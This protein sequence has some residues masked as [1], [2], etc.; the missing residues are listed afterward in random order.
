ME[1]DWELIGLVAREETPYSVFAIFS[2]ID[3]NSGLLAFTASDNNE[4][5]GIFTDINDA[6]DLMYERLR[7]R[8]SACDSSHTFYD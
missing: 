1:H 2:I 5:I 3:K 7:L 8:R 4:A 6:Y